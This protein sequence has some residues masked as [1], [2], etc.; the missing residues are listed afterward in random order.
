MNLASILLAVKF[1]HTQ[2]TTKFCKISNIDLSYVVPIKS[3]VEIFQ[4]FVASSE[5]MNV[6][7]HNETT[8]ILQEGRDVL[9][10]IKISENISTYCEGTMRAQ[11]RVKMILLIN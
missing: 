6:T 2:R 1:I 11:P 8:K 10:D 7:V 5:Y 4:H 3:T 9:L